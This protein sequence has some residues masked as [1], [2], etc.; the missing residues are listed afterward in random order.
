MIP[1]Y[2][3]FRSECPDRFTLT[4]INGAVSLET[5][6]FYI[7]FHSRAG[8]S[9][10]SPSRTISS[11]GVRVTLEPDLILETEEVFWVVIAAE[12]TGD[13]QDARILAMWQARNDDQTSRRS[14]PV[15]ID[16]TQ[17]EHFRLGRITTDVAILPQT[18]MIEGAIAFDAATEIYYRYDPDAFTDTNGRLFSYGAIT[19]G[20]GKWVEHGGTFNAYLASTNDVYGS[21]RK[22]FSVA[23][24]L[25]IPPKIGAAT[26]Q[27]QRYWLNNGLAADGESPIIAAKFTLDIAV[28]AVPGYEGVFANKIRYYLRGYINR[29]T[30]VLNTAI[31][32]VG[33]PKLWNPTDGL[34][35]LPEELPR[36]HAAVYDLELV[37]DNDELIG[38]VPQNASIQLDIVEVPNIRGKVSELAKII[39]NLVFSD[40]DKLAIVPGLKRLSGIASI[41]EGFLIEDKNEQLITGLVADT[42]DQ[43]VTLTG[44]LNGL[45]AVKTGALGYSEVLRAKVS[46]QPGISALTPSSQISLTNNAISL[47]VTHPLTTEG[48]G[49]IRANYPD[50]LIA[51]S[52]KARFT[53]TE[54]YVFLQVGS[55]FYQSDLLQVTAIATQTINLDLADFTSIPSLPVQAD[56]S[57]G[58]FAP[59]SVTLTSRG[60][61]G[62]TGNTTAY[63]AYAYS[64]PNQIETKI[65]N[66]PLGSIPTALV[67]L[68]EAINNANTLAKS[69]NLNDLPS[70]AIARQ[71]LGV[72][73]TSDI[74]S[75]N[76]QFQ[77]TIK[78]IDANYTVQSEDNN[79][80]L[81]C[82]DTSD[83]TIILDHTLL[84]LS[85]GFQL[86]IRKAATGNINIAIA[87]GATHEGAALTITQLYGCIYFYYKGGLVW[88]S[89]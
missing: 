1:T 89:I 81:D 11:T 55:N 88:M 32:T 73:S 21:D 54:C 66:Q 82:I 60:T 53:P 2:A 34:I 41:G 64:S 29:E 83:I 72:Y 39:G 87:G 35:I 49:I 33:E 68:A 4:G 75:F 67:T 61:G 27:Q 23:N 63:F 85:N 38:L 84:D 12:T 16:F 25:K 44:S 42:Q 43:K 15:S 7:S 59:S 28:D 19:R 50:A 9:L 86:I 62:V 10:L 58:L 65:S 40:L 70:K 22:L 51:G 8:R 13:P 31:A 24:A 17:E 6:N 74:D 71:N 77:T 46:T 20:Q 80:I 5:R 37:F 36:N 30:L 14:L 78:E 57:F 26:S 56:P 3:S 47:V 52:Q 76:S 45:A 48:A 18:G 69:E 79:T